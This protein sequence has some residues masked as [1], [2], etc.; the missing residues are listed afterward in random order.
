MTTVNEFLST[1]TAGAA[2]E[3]RRKQRM[4]PTRRGKVLSL[5]RANGEWLAIVA[6]FTSKRDEPVVSL[7]V[8][9]AHLK[10]S[11][12]RKADRWVRELA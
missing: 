4:K 8:P 12:R 7:I 3:E 5:M 10:G 2:R 1:M 9:I 6:A 11:A